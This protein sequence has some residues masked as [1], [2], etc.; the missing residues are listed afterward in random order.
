MIT[1]DDVFE[2][3]RN[4]KNVVHRT[5]LVFS[6]TLSDITG[7]NV[8]LKLENLQRTG[9]FKIRGAYNRIYKIK[10]P[11]TRV[12]AASA[13]NHAQGVALAAKILNL[14]ATV[15][16]PEGTP[17]NK[18]L[19]VKNYGA[20]V[21]LKGQNFDEAYA[22]ARALEKDTGYMFIHPFDDSDVISGQGTIGLEISQQLKEIDAVVVPVGGGGLISGI[23]LALTAYNSDIDIY[24]VES[25]N[26]PA[27]SL[28]LKAG[29]IV[30]A[31]SQPTLADGIAVRKVGEITF[32]LVKRYVREVITIEESEIEDVLLYLSQYKNLVVEGAGA[33][34]LAGL[35]RVGKNLSGKNVVVVISG[36]N[37]DI[38]VLSKI[39]ERGMVKSGRLMRLEV[40]LPDVPGA[41]GKLSSLL[42]EMKANIVHIFHDRLSEGLPLDR[43]MVEV[44][45]ETRDYD[46][47]KSIIR[48]LERYGY[49]PREM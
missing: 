13:G 20:E 46:H 19:A 8:Y 3:Y 48:T 36:G 21:I 4:I 37:I 26:V 45:L 7:A 49:R 5:P 34:S 6:Y 15:V 31:P 39:I 24:G 11:K 17:I 41:L 35:Y 9:S 33:V 25:K 14:K 28:S 23:A 18:V 43:A 44:T 16:M 47:Q 2:A 32:E 30:E 10:D 40:E 22:F 29:R 27:M 38:N 12:L 42:G 1:V